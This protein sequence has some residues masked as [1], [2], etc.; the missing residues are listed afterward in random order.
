MTSGAEPLVEILNRLLKGF[1]WLLKIMFCHEVP[2]PSYYSEI[3]HRK[4]LVRREKLQMSNRKNST[5]ARSPVRRHRQNPAEKQHVMDTSLLAGR[6]VLVFGAGAVGSHEVESL[7]SAA[8]LIFD[9]VDHDVVDPKHTRGGRTAYDVSHI[10]MYK[11]DALKAK[12]E[13]DHP[14]SIVNKHVRNI[15]DFT[16]M[17]LIELARKADVVLNAAD[18]GKA[19][20]RINALL[21]PFIEILYVAMHQRAASGHI[22]ITFPYASPCLCCS[23]GV[24][25]PEDIQ[26]LHGEPGPSLDIQ[27]I[28]KHGATFALEIIYSKVTGKQIE[29]WDITKNIIYFANRRERLS[30][31]GPGVILQKARKLPGC[32]I[33]SVNPTNL[34]IKEN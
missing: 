9:V 16:D 24:R 33:C 13:R 5:F 8:D 27:L 20:F 11:V 29:R 28:A 2:N 10:G 22:I 34:T 15:M 6:R 17:E 30:P 7:A 3:S 23:L 26:T 25:Y 18:D 19:M 1:L 14:E 4:S 21:Y 32:P 31:D 12:I